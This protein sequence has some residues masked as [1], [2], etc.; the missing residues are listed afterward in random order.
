M[1]T[2]TDDAGNS[3]SNSINLKMQESFPDLTITKSEVNVFGGVKIQI[4]GNRLLIAD[5]EV[6]SW[7]DKIAEPCN[8]S[9]SLNGND[10]NDGDT[11]GEP[12]KLTITVTNSQERSSAAEIIL[13]NETVYG[14]EGIMCLSMQVGVECDLL[15]GVSF[16]DG[17][18]LVQLEIEQDGQRTVI[19]DAAHF[20]PQYPGLC[21]I[22]FTVQKN[23]T[24]NEVKVDNLTIRPLDYKAINIANIRPVDILPII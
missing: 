19:A 23:G 12:G 17:A 10:V 22:I 4:N 3:A 5:E 21:C 14:I 13:T 16:V 9:L 2:V 8:V 20:I 24:A 7:S 1:L 15:Q 18:E 11:L 6:A